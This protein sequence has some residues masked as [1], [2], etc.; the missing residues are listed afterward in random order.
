MI[1]GELRN[2]WEL[3]SSSADRSRQLESTAR[4][5][6]RILG[7][8]E[9]NGNCYFMQQAEEGRMESLATADVIKDVI[10]EKTFEYMCTYVLC[11]VCDIDRSTRTE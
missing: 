6:F 8:R 2:E 9:W 3:A 11:L 4:R 10:K 1:T 7:I 5:F